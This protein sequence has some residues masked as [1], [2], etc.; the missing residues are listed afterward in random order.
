MRTHAHNSIQA[1]VSL[2]QESELKRCMCQEAVEVVLL[3]AEVE[4]QGWLLKTK[5]LASCTCFPFEGYAGLCVN[6]TKYPL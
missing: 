5:Q 3:Q 6:V 4:M 1:A 2:A